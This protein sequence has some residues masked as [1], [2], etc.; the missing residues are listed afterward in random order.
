MINAHRGWFKS[1][2]FDFLYPLLYVFVGDIIHQQTFG[3]RQ[4]GILLTEFLL[5]V[6]DVA[7]AGSHEGDDCLTLQIV[8]LYEG[9]DDGRVGIPPVGIADKDHR[10][11]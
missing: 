1:L 3:E 9:I 5:A 10:I 8:R 11:L 4:I 6:D 7:A 2:F